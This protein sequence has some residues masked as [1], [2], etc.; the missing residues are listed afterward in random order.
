MGHCVHVP[1]RGWL[2]SWGGGGKTPALSCR[3]GGYHLA[4]QCHLLVLKHAMQLTAPRSVFTLAF[5]QSHLLLGT[6]P[7]HK[8]SN[9][10]GQASRGLQPGTGKPGTVGSPSQLSR[11]IFLCSFQTCFLLVP[12]Q[13]VSPWSLC[14]WPAL[15]ASPF[16][17]PTNSELTEYQFQILDKKNMRSSA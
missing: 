12:L 13:Q 15:L 16:K 3:L 7:A 4:V 8:R 9:L 10:E 5:L 2:C 1:I 14:S 17:I 11:A 6:E